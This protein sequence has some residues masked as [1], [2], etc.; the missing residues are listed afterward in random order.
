MARTRRAFCRGNAPTH[1]RLMVDFRSKLE[2]DSSITAND[3]E[4]LGASVPWQQFS[5]IER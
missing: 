5:S 1:Q 2:S 4:T 3:G